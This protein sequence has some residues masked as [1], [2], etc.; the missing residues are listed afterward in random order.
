MFYIF[1]I[2]LKFHSC[3][4]E[5]LSEF[6]IEANENSH[7]LT[8]RIFSYPNKKESFLIKRYF[9]DVRSCKILYPFKIF[10]FKDRLYKKIWDCLC[11]LPIEFNKEELKEMISYGIVLEKNDYNIAKS[12]FCSLIR[13]EHSKIILD[14]FESLRTNLIKNIIYEIFKELDNISMNDSSYE[15]ECIYKIIYEN[16]G[17]LLVEFSN[18]M[19]DN[20]QKKFRNFFKEIYSKILSKIKNMHKVSFP[21]LYKE[22]NIFYENLYNI[23]IE[24]INDIELKNFKKFINIIQMFDECRLN[25]NP[26]EYQKINIK[27]I[28]LVIKFISD[29][30]SKIIDL[31]K[32]QEENYRIFFSIDYLYN[33]LLSYCTE[34]IPVTLKN[35]NGDI[36]NCQTYSECDNFSSISFEFK[37]VHILDI[38]N[39]YDLKTVSLKSNY[40]SI[41]KNFLNFIISLN[42]LK[43][44]IKKSFIFQLNSYNII[45]A[46]YI[47]HFLIFLSFFSSKYHT[48]SIDLFYKGYIGGKYISTEKYSFENEVSLSFL[49][50]EI[51]KSYKYYQSLNKLS[52]DAR[53]SFQKFWDL[54][55]PDV[56]NN[57]VFLLKLCEDFI[58][59]IPLQTKI[60]FKIRNHI[61]SKNLNSD[62]DS[63]C[64]C[65]E[66]DD[67]S[68]DSR[69]AELGPH[70]KRFLVFG[71]AKKIC[72]RNTLLNIVGVFVGNFFYI[73]LVKHESGLYH[74]EM[75]NLNFNFKNISLPKYC[76]CI[77]TFSRFYINFYGLFSFT[78][79]LKNILVFKKINLDD[80]YLSAENVI[81]NILM[82][83]NEIR[84]IHF[85]NSES[86]ICL[87]TQNNRISTQSIILLLFF[88]GCKF[89]NGLEV[90]GQFDTIKLRTC[91]IIDKI[92]FFQN[93]KFKTLSIQNCIGNV[94]LNGLSLGPNIHNSLGEILIKKNSF[95][96]IKNYKVDG[97]L[98]LPFEIFSIYI[99]NSK[100]S[101][102]IDLFL[103][104][105]AIKNCTGFFY[106]NLQKF[107]YD[108][109]KIEI[110]NDSIFEIDTSNRKKNFNFKNL[111][112]HHDPK[113]F[114]I[115]QQQFKINITNC[116]SAESQGFE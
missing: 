76:V 98:S 110:E 81:F 60:A 97:F 96:E 109:G 55:T 83:P 37:N 103:S 6:I 21:Y 63:T 7:E 26:Q 64:F 94:F 80:T 70:F 35:D 10:G 11:G 91:I 72:I 101:L 45:N 69:F 4:K 67:N 2:L 57:Y 14:Y 106:L 56:D 92:Y 95:C 15:K 113:K 19:S 104:K 84:T 38:W 99:T 74:P 79:N 46:E 114:L 90:I 24:K 36:L 61:F 68:I 47:Q 25:T 43:I 111:Y 1:Q 89:F 22:L 3:T 13:K 71:S 42:N 44:D 65:F 33:N 9:E 82:I 20:N 88:D 16:N 77:E 105:I 18:I 86:E 116:S 31:Q 41:D 29:E 49:R 34:N 73:F 5:N 40:S 51:R 107:G 87:N 112:F 102:H 53:I 28:E 93:C 66:S 59:P 108:F 52:K 115:E 100:I 39:W 85:I 78:G 48:I 27:D 75:I 23:Y 50:Y 17:K 32:F 58:D 30:I 62:S 12:I 8:R 54:L